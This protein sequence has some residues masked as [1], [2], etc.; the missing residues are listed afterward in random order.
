MQLRSIVEA[1]RNGSKALMESI[2]RIHTTNMMIEE[3][4]PRLK[5]FYFTFSW[6]IS[7]FMKKIS[8]KLTRTWLKP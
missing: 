7:R 1:T 4:E 3:N 6:I 5:K 2:N 8:I